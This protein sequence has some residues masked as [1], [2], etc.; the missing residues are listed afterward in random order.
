M[1]DN[2]DNQLNALRGD[3]DS[4]VERDSDRERR[5]K[6]LELK[7]EALLDRVEGVEKNVETLEDDGP[8]GPDKDVDASGV[9]TKT[10]RYTGQGASFNIQQVIELPFQMEFNFTTGTHDNVKFLG[11]WPLLIL[12]RILLRFYGDWSTLA[13]HRYQIFQAYPDWYKTKLAGFSSPS[14]ILAEGTIAGS[15][16]VSGDK[17]IQ[18]GI[19]A[20]MTENPQ[21][22]YINIL[23]GL[24][25]GWT[26]TGYIDGAIMCQ[27]GYIPSL[28]T[29]RAA[30]VAQIQANRSRG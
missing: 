22:L 14:T 6:S 21:A 24:V 30:E 9:N 4:N 11:F 28:G 26:G 25:G 12:D 8:I 23:P 15:A 2:Y 29:M 19:D 17:S 13:S 3:L 10:L 20:A 5:L 18:I 27:K 16:I 7:V 1:A